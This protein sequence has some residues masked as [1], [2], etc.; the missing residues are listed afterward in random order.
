MVVFEDFTKQY[1]VSKTLRFELIP[2][3][4]TLENMERAGIVKGDCQRSEDYQKAKKIIDKIYKHILNSSMSK[5]EIDWSTLAEATKEFRKNK[6]KKKYENVQVSVRKKLLEA[7]KNK[8]IPVGKGTKDLYKA[9]F[10]K[11]IVTGEVCAAFPGI[12]LTDEEKA[13]LDKFKKFTTY[14]TGFFENR[15][16]IFTDEGISTS[17]TYRLVNDNFIKFY[18]NC[19]LYKDIIASVPGLKD[20][21]KKCFED[22]QLFSERR[23]EEIFET[24]FYNH[25]LTQDGID[26]F[27]QLLGG[28]STKEGEKKKQGLNEVINLAMQKDEG[29]RNKLRY[30]A[31]KFT[32][33]FKQILNDRS[34]LSF[35]P[36]SFKDGAEVLNAVSTYTAYL[37]GQDILKRIRELIQSMDQYDP[38]SLSIDGKYISKLSQAV[39]ASWNEIRDRVKEYKRSLLKKETKATLNKIDSE[40]KS[41]VT[42]QEILANPPDKNFYMAINSYV[43]NLIQNC[44]NTLSQSLPCELETAEDKSKIKIL[45][46][47]TLDLYRFLEIFSHDNSQ[48]V[49]TAFEE[50][51]TEILADM[52]ETVPLYNKVRNFATKKAYSIEKFKLNFKNS[53]LASGWD[54]HK[55]NDYKAIL[56]KRNEEYFIGILMDRIKLN[57][58][59]CLESN[60]DCYKF[61]IYKQFDVRQQLPR[62]AFC[63]AVKQ[64]FR[65]GKTAS[66]KLETV[67]FIKPL[68]I[69]KEIYDLYTN[70]YASQFDESGEI[71]KFSKRYLELSNDEE[72][73]KAAV[74]LWID[75]IKQFISSYK[76]MSEFKSAELL[77]ANQYES[78]AEIYSKFDEISYEVTFENVSQAFIDSCVE[79]GSLYLF[80]L[81]TKDFSPGASGKPNLHTLYWKYVFEEENLKDVVVKLNG[82]AE[83]FYRPRSL[84]QPVVH[85]KG[86]KILNK[87]TSSGEP[88]PDNVYVELSHFIKNGSTG[89]LSEEAKNWQAKVSVRNVPHMITKDRRF[90]QDKFFFHVPLTLNYKSANTP[91]RFNDLVKEYIKKNTDVHVIG[92]DRGERN[93]IYAVVINGEGKIVEQRSF[94]IVGGYNYQEKL[95]QKENER[96]AAR[97]DWTAVTSIKDLKQG[98]LSAVVHELSKMIVKYKAIVV[99]ENLN[100]GFKR[101]RGGIAE[102]S[103]YQQ[104]EK[105]L[106]DKLNYLVFKDAVPTAPGGVLNAYQLTDKF[107]SFSKMNQ[108]TGFLFYVPAAYTSKIDPLTGFVDCFNWKQIK[109]NS[110]SRKAFIGLFESLYYD[111]NTNNFVLHYRHKAN[112]YVRGDNLDITEWE[113]LI[114]ENKK[115]VSKTNKSYCQGKRIIYRKGSGN[116]GGASPYYPHEELQSL[117]KGYGISYK[118][119][120][121][122]LPKIKAANDN[123]LVEKLHYIIKA[124]LQLRNSNSET[125]E[126]YISSPI[127]GCEEWCF[128]SRAADDALPQDADANGAFHIAMKGLLLM[129]RIRNDEKLAISNEDWL[130]YIQGLRS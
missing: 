85:K 53:T 128:D 70:N 84:T 2:Q 47:S 44:Y 87:T 107:D 96:Q 77:L 57:E 31:H 109:K 122:I 81:H 55:I 113:I 104:F 35:I 41:G 25:I 69:T 92:I 64:H 48:G 49:K 101:M 121:N 88:V 102:R 93:L 76:R 99:L 119:G 106:I 13:I 4:K 63:K 124:V 60:H 117:L 83:L 97:R 116:H 68:V 29:I 114:Q 78:L 66:Y 67:S 91:P 123:A 65:S 130:N 74:A 23:L 22:L 75:F 120:E 37:S 26:E 108:Q 50:Q 86:E 127:E 12:D 56:L 32:P 39:F 98:Y 80:K 73:Y 33:L 24:S 110:E 15:K 21:F 5:V 45:M 118:A 105:A 126:D 111:A 27:N 10:E 38:D 1:Q 43:E 16:N 62:I 59:R 61:I 30:R 125:G 11:E 112:R 34:T 6:D 103:V 7:I 20:E 17:F 42:V 58:A 52:K 72:G 36:E 28:I 89:N 79:N 40:I 19:N 100:V 46:D 82:Q 51:L 9:M 95:W 54:I 3:G 14:F 71:K 94:N 129:K 115:V 90:T 18:D 8:P